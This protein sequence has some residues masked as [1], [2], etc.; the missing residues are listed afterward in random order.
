M[1]KGLLAKPQST[2]R[3]SPLAGASAT[4]SLAIY[5]MASL[6]KLSSFALTATLGAG[7]TAT[8]SINDINAII[9]AEQLLHT[10]R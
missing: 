4:P 9:H 6:D 5:E 2:C 10:W 8:I 1:E 7:R 3:T